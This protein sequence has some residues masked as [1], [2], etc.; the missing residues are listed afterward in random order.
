MARP[1]V[2]PRRHR[3]STNESSMRYH[4]RAGANPRRC[5]RSAVAKSTCR[6]EEARTGTD[7]GV[8]TRRHETASANQRRCRRASAM[9]CHEGTRKW[10][11]W[12]FGTLEG[13]R[14]EK[15][16]S[17]QKGVLRPA[18]VTA[19]QNRSEGGTTSNRNKH[20]SVTISHRPILPLRSK[21]VSVLRP[22]EGH[23]AVLGGAK[24]LK[25]RYNRVTLRLSSRASPRV[26]QLAT[27]VGPRGS[28]TGIPG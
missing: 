10:V 26:S 6:C 4:Q 27:A 12:E 24:A 16:P 7:A 23:G 5:R 11:S 22:I 8:D 2:K 25:Q 3:K 19:H 17:R 15:E 14:L 28:R 20:T 13:S 18:R 9:H 1:G 21:S